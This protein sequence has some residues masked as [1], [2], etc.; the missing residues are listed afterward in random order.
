M[1]DRLSRIIEEILLKQPTLKKDDIITLIAEKKKRVGSGFLTD[2]GAAY[3]VASDL[4]LEITDTDRRN[5]SLK[6]LSVGLSNITISCFMLNMPKPRRFVRKD[7][8][9][10]H[11]IRMSVFDDNIIVPVLI[12]DISRVKEIQGVQ[13]GQAVLIENAL[14]KLGRDGKLEIHLSSQSNLALDPKPKTKSLDSITKSVSGIASPSKHLVVQGIISSPPKEIQFRR[15]DGSEGKAIQL[16][17]QDQSQMNLKARVIIWSPIS[18]TMGKLIE[19]SLVRFVDIEARTGRSG[20]L[21]L[22]GSEDTTV[23]NLGTLSQPNQSDEITFT[24]LSIGPASDDMGRR[25]A[26]LSDGSNVV[27]LTV[28]GRASSIFDDLTIGDILKIRNYTLKDRQIILVNPLNDI[29]IIGSDEQYLSKYIIKINQITQALAAVSV[30]AVA[31]SKPVSKS[32]ALRDG[33]TV[34][35]TE[36]LVGDET[37][38][39]EII[40]WGRLAEQLS[41]IMPGTRLFMHG[42]SPT[43]GPSETIKLQLKEYSSIQK[44]QT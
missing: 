33:R 14:T 18:A 42:L 13:P 39:T 8:S 24:L 40:A 36:L 38:E 20:E 3:L 11:Y 34:Q 22:H 27:T 21:E 37:G 29:K 15:H 44:I 35:R 28:S 4:G 32:I 17:L 43:V 16:T 1:E 31:L 30:E 23:E 2:A 6:D 25:V 12:W 7:G 26:L 9:E 5:Y 10:S 41:G 19:N